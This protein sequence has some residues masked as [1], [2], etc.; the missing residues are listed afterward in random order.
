MRT[1]PSP[2]AWLPALRR[3]GPQSGEPALL[4]GPG[5]AI[6]ALPRQESDEAAPRVGEQRTGPPREHVIAAGDEAGLQQC[7]DLLPRPLGAWA[8][9]DEMAVQ[10][11]VVAG[12]DED[13]NLHKP[14][15]ARARGRPTAVSVSA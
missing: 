11:F 15:E 13:A 12:E 4:R 14:P 5:L 6:A 7:C 10:G 2:T 9:V 8:E 3:L 1:G